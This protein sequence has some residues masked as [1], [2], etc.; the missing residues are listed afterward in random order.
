MTV[1]NSKLKALRAT[2]TT[3]TLSGLPGMFSCGLDALAVVGNAASFASLSDAQRILLTEA[4]QNVIPSMAALQRNTEELGSLC[5]RGKAQTIQASEAEIKQLRDGFAPVYQWLRG[6]ASTAR[7]LDQIDAL[8]TG[9][10]ADPNDVPDCSGLSQA[11]A[12]EAVSP[13]D[14]SY[15]A[16]V[17]KSDLLSARRTAGPTTSRTTASSGLYLIVASSPIH[18]NRHRRAPG[19]TGRSL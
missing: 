6:D 3:T 19:P 10:T 12:P 4:I 2:N 13:I 1:L 9:L 15:L 18:S 11:S 14:G 5:R 7:Y 8:K 16:K 17:T